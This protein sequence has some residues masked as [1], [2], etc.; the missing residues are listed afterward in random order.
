MSEWKNRAISLN[1]H[2]WGK[3]RLQYEGAERGLRPKFARPRLRHQKIHPRRICQ[4]DDGI[5]E[6]NPE[7]KELE[8]HPNELLKLIA[9][10]LTPED[11]ERLMSEYDNTNFGQS[12]ESSTIPFPTGALQTK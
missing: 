2:R 7:Y 10:N 12:P 1:L 5:I 9:A 3:A 4:I 6:S 8:K 11:K